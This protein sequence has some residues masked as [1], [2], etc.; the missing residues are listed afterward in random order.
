M[1]PLRIRRIRPMRLPRFLRCPGRNWLIYC[2]LE[3]HAPAVQFT[4]TGKAAAA[5]LNGGVTVN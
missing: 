2:P 5:M 4:F 1:N 3:A